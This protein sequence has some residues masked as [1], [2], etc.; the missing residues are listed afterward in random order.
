MESEGTEG[1]G[2][3]D[4]T[5]LITTASEP[6]EN[7]DSLFCLDQTGLRLRMTNLALQDTTVVDRVLE[8]PIPADNADLLGVDKVVY[9]KNG[10]NQDAGKRTYANGTFSIRDKFG[11]D[12]ASGT[13][14]FINLYTVYA[15]P[16]ENKATG[17]FI[18]SPGSPMAEE[19]LADLS[20]LSFDADI[21]FT[22]NPLFADNPSGGDEERYTLFGGTLTLIPSTT[23]LLTDP[24]TV[25][26]ELNTQGNIPAG[27]LDS[28]NLVVAL[29]ADALQLSQHLASPVME[30]LAS[31]E[32]IEQK[33]TA[34][35][36]Q[37]MVICQ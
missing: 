35:W 19:L 6:P 3:P 24:G 17:R 7:Y 31:W 13:I 2:T 23:S 14:P 9:Y 11:T 22:Q 33:R 21:A 8:G 1:S 30:H 5:E 26:G 15:V 27:K 12:V 32:S 18:L 4:T 36:H 16:L 34:Y 28:Y 29:T 20:T 10:S 25:N 37:P